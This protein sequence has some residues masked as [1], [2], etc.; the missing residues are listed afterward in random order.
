M[1]KAA[2]REVPPT[3]V[4]WITDKLEVFDPQAPWQG[5]RVAH[6]LP[7]G[8]EAYVKV[9]DFVWEDTVIPDFRGSKDRWR[10]HELPF[11]TVLPGLAP[12]RENERPFP[13]ASERL[14]RTR[15]QALAD[16][17]ALTVHPEFSASS[18]NGRTE[19]GGRW[20][21]R[22]I[23]GKEGTLCEPAFLA[24][25]AA[26]AGHGDLYFHWDAPKMLRGGH[27]G[28]GLVLEGPAGTVPQNWPARVDLMPSHIWPRDRSWIIAMDHELT[29]ALVAC[30]AERAKTLLQH[31]ELECLPMRPEHRIDAEADRQNA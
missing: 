13:Y 9:L 7:P 3:E 28:G 20:P 18:F 5:S 22:I 4:R 29:F 23:V 6:V 27:T 2:W 25:L 14:K 26:L 21:A 15:W 12:G 19:D 30:A 1:K 16:K 17:F 11:G 24:L 31:A 8:F 10:M